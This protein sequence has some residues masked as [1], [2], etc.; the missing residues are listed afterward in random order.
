MRPVVYLAFMAICLSS[1]NFILKERAEKEPEVKPDKKVV[2]GTDQDSH[3]CVASAGY[4]WCA[5]RNECVRIFEEGYR[6]NPVTEPQEEGIAES[7]F[8]IFEE[9]GDRAELYLPDSIN[10]ITLKRTTKDGPFI[11]DHWTLHPEN[12]YTLKKD[13]Q[14]AFVAAKIEE[15]KVTG[16]Y[17]QQS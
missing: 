16:D 11:S 17:N 6:L 15:N 12:G 14:T 4:R 10:S 9:N 2:L 1:C 8:V 13:G 7:A 5:M 3:G